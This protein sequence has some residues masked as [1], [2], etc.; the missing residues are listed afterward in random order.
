ML[1]AALVFTFAH[2]AFQSIP[3]VRTEV[4]APIHMD[5]FSKGGKAKVR[6]QGGN[7]RTENGV[8]L[9]DGSQDG[10]RQVD[11]QIAVGNGFVLHG[12]NGGLII[13]DKKG[14]YV[15]GVPQTEF[16]NGI[17]PKLFYD[18]NR[19]VFGFDMWVYWDKAK[20]KPVNISVSQTADPRG[21][22]NTYPVPAPGGVDGGAIGHSRKWIGYSFPGGPEEAFVLKMSDAVAGKPATIY[23]FKGSLGEPVNTQDAIDDLYFVKITDTDIVITRVSDAGDGTPVVASVVR[24]PHHL[25][26]WDYPPDSPQKG[27]DKRTASGDRN[28]KNLVVQNHYLWFSQAVDIEGR[29][30]VQWHQVSLDGKFLQS[31][32]I[33]DPVNSYIETTLAVNKHN[34]VL[35][36]F[37]EVGPGMYISPRC[38]YRLAKDPPGTLRGIIHLG[39][40]L[41][42][43]AG[44]AWG[45]YSG[46]VVD[47]DNR[48]DFWTIQSLATA[49]GGGG[50]VIAKVQPHK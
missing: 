36:G 27:T 32:R 47:G 2:Q 44:G 33:A 23:H 11:P 41:G 3:P 38:A 34:D 40:G 42:A 10:D 30:A 13:Y 35:V 4:I 25:Q 8:F 46:S 12:T 16:N 21:A 39:E 24:K 5:S 48:L 37:Q 26:Y 29:S 9:F 6:R 15:E 28:P 45:D 43:T 50:T 31:G 19:R 49:K 14:T 22:W 17:D 1:F 7:P 20:I 18:V